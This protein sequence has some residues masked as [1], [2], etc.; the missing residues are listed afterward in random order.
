ML[1]PLNPLIQWRVW[2]IDLSV[3]PPRVHTF[4]NTMGTP[5]DCQAYEDQFALTISQKSSDGRTVEHVPTSA[6]FAFLDLHQM[7]TGTT[8]EEIE[9]YKARGISF[10][11]NINAASLPSE[12]HRN[13]MEFPYIDDDFPSMAPSGSFGIADED[14]FDASKSRERIV[15]LGRP[16]PLL[17]GI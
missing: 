5:A 12:F 11:A 7:W 10:S 17:D 2:Y 1:R 4:D 14:R 3:S 16:S 6:R 9:E 15:R 8:L 13:A